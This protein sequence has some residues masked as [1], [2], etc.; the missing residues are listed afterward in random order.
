MFQPVFHCG[1]EKLVKAMVTAV[2]RHFCID[3]KFFLAQVDL[4]RSMFAN[5]Y[6]LFF[7]AET[8]SAQNDAIKDFVTLR[9]EARV[10][11]EM[12]VFCQGLAA[13]A[14]LPRRSL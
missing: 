12:M 13:G 8:W 5:R 7:D 4:E 11:D 1:S 6:A 2:A 9:K 14:A 10:E 3:R